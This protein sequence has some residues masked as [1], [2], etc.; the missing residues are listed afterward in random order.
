MVLQKFLDQILQVKIL[1]NVFVITAR[2]TRTNLLSCL[3]SFLEVWQK[4]ALTEGI[5]F[6]LEFIDNPH[7]GFC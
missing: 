7:Y 3:V 4:H 5:I 1:P 2:Q 6:L